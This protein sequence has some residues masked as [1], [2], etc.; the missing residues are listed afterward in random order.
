[1]QFMGA[2][3]TLPCPQGGANDPC[4]ETV[5]SILKNIVQYVCLLSVE[6]KGA[7]F[8]CTK[9]LTIDRTLVFPCPPSSH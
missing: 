1:M 4:F 3:G 5:K 7:Y 9:V 2:E 8:C 6:N